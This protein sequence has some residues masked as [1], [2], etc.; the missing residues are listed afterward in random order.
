[1]QETENEI[2]TWFLSPLGDAACAPCNMPNRNQSEH[3]YEQAVTVGMVYEA[4]EKLLEGSCPK[5][6]KICA[7]K[8]S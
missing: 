3:L 8:N 6:Q 2:L 7:N 1:M 5:Q 4:A